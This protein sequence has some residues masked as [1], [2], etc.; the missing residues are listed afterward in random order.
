M[1]TDT[2][3]EDVCLQTKLTLTASQAGDAYAWTKNGQPLSDNTRTI[4]I[5]ATEDTATYVCDVQTETQS[6]LYNLMANGDFESNPP[7]AF[8]SDYQ[9]AGWNP[10]QYYSNHAGAANLYAITGD[11]SY[12]WHDFAPVKPHSGS[13]FALFDAGTDGYAW[14]AETA[15]NPNLIIEKDS[16]YLFSYWAA[17]PNQSAGN[18]PAQLQFVIVCTDQNN[19]KQTFNLGSVYTLGN[20]SP[21]NAWVQQTVTWKAPISSSNVMIGVYDKN[22]SSGGNDFCLDDIMFQKTTATLTTVVHRTVFIVTARDC[23]PV[24]PEDPEDPED[25]EKPDEPCVGQ[26]QYAKW[27]D[28]IFIPNGDHRYVS[29]QWYRDGAPIPG[30]TEQYLYEPDGLFGLYHC[31]MQTVSGTTEASC[32]AEFNDIPR[33]ADLNPGFKRVQSR[34][35]YHVSDHFRILVTNYDDGTISTEKQL[36][37][38]TF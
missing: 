7:V 9:Y 3:T 5:Q 27:Q 19:Q 4:I 6:L 37:W 32:P 28:V 33:S 14:K 26:P 12:F 38:P 2:V 1:P 8:S 30:A 10:S 25:P 36:L 22:R 15:N 34:H 17:Y 29:Y 16:T 11:A 20:T 21:L 35:I 31:V 18:S 23:T 13:W 24:V